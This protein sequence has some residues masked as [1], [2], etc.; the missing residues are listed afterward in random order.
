MGMRGAVVAGADRKRSHWLDCSS[1]GSDSR[2][3]QDTLLGLRRGSL[4]RS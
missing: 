4:T 3:A 1:L 2:R